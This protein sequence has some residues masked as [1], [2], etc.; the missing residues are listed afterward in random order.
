M[1]VPDTLDYKMKLF[2]SRGFLVRYEWET[3]YDPSWLALY[4]G[5]GFLPEHYDP[6]ADYFPVSE[7]RDQLARMRGNIAS[8]VQQT[9]THAEFIARHCTAGDGSAAR[10][11]SNAA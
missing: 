9:P 1:S 2:R 10:W 11:G 8:I 4:T 7:V 3:F 6:L 5:F